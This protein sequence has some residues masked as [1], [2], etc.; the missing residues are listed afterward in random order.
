MLCEAGVVLVSEEALALVACF[1]PLKAGWGVLRV[2]VGFSKGFVGFSKGFVGFSKG[3]VGV[4]KVFVGFSKG[5]VGVSKGFVNQGGWEPQDADRT[6]F[7][8]TTEHSPP[9]RE[10]PHQNK[11]VRSLRTHFAALWEVQESVMVLLFALTT[12]QR[13]PRKNRRKI[14]H[15][16]KPNAQRESPNVPQKRKNLESQLPI[17]SDRKKKK[18]KKKTHPV[19]A[20]NSAFATLHMLSHETLLDTIHLQK[21]ATAWQLVV[22]ASV[23][24]GPKLLFFFWFKK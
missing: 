2:F 17:K 15:L 5:F 9:S 12:L 21:A 20:L 16:K 19:P 11:K 18:K 24:L 13:H 10:S 7:E 4:S 23:P 14:L 22:P 6:K 1:Q 3:F 8:E